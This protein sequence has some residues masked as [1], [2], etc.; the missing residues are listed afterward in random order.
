MRS[1]LQRPRVLS[2]TSEAVEYEDLAA[3][4]FPKPRIRLSNPRLVLPL[5]V[6]IIL[7]KRKGLAAV[8]LIY[9]R[10]T[11]PMPQRDGN[12]LHKYEGVLRTGELKSFADFR[13]EIMR[14]IDAAA[15]RGIILRLLGGAAIRIHSPGSEH[16]Y[17]LLKR[18]PKHDM[19]FVSYS[20]YR[21]LTRKL[22]K[23]MGYT[24]YLTLAMTSG[25]GRHRQIFN[26]SEGNKAIDVFF[27]KLPMCHVIEF[28]GR[29]E[30]DHP[31][32]PLAELF[33]QKAQ[34]CEMNEKDWQD[35]CI[36]L[37]EHPVADGDKDAVNLGHVS[38][39]LA[40]D[41]GFY[42]TVST[43]L[44]KLRGYVVECPGLSGNDRASIEG[45]I[46]MISDAIEKEP[47]ALK[48]KM[49]AKVG[50]SRKWYNVVEEVERDTI[51]G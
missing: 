6:E 29:L 18:A 37:R 16:M 31:T 1:H 35:M 8:R 14:I 17:D 44:S 38:K 7:F 32:I 11:V 47:K 3:I 25:A 5:S 4:L 13:E 39:L 46:N 45:K 24:P 15:E 28:E 43:N 34:I 10:A 27:D 33:L 50:T 22:M 30:A 36:L 40:N 12:R 9:I 48:W 2:Q 49:R 51:S 20:K 26:D 42:Y 21:P 19:D 41:W 23:E